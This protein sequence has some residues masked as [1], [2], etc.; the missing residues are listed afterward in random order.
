ML[1]INLSMLPKAI[2]NN[3]WFLPLWL[4]VVYNFRRALP[5]AQRLVIV[6]L[7]YAAAVGVA[8][9]WHEVRLWLPVVILVAPVAVG[10]F[11]RKPDDALR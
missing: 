10:A 8:A 4:L 11:S 1:E 2:L 9:T 6:A 7:G 5:E 3:I